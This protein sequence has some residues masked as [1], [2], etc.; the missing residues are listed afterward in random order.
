MPFIGFHSAM[1]I[2]H[3]VGTLHIPLKKPLITLLLV[4][5]D[6]ITPYHW[7]ISEWTN[8][9]VPHSAMPSNSTLDLIPKQMLYVVKFDL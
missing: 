6:F 9:I 1:V 4:Y 7:T 8:T 5:K 2:S 3:N